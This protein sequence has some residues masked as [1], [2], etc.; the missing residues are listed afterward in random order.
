[1]PIRHLGLLAA[2]LALVISA[3]PVVAQDHRG[4]GNDA[5]TGNSARLCKKFFGKGDGVILQCFQKNKTR[6][7]APCRNFLGGLGLLN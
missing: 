2:A 1:M 6:L 5:C 7:S 4:R 3:T